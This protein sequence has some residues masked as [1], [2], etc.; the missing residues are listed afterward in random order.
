MAWGSVPPALRARLRVA[1]VARL[2]TLGAH[3]VPHAVPVCFAYHSG[4]FYSPIDRKPKS[5][6]PEKLARLR[7]IAARPQVALLIDHYE[8]DWTKLWFV[9]IRGK[10]VLLPESA[11]RERVAAMRA[12]K[13]KYRQYATGMLPD[14]ALLI[15]IAPQRISHW[16][17][18]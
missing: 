11:R 6:A 8:E 17:S 12:L 10:A 9:L 5:V 3:G 1:R 4:F 18:H 13:K 7:N 15:R 14:D 16:Q 2:T